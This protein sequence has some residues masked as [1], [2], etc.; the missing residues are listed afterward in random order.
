MGFRVTNPTDRDLRL[1]V[2]TSYAE[3][4]D[5]QY[6]RD[7][8]VP[9]HSTLTSWFAAG[10]PASALS[11][12]I[13][14][15]GSY[16]YDRSSG[17][18]RLI[19][20]KDGP[21]LWR[22]MARYTRRGPGT[23]VMLD[24]EL[25]DGTWQPTPAGDARADGV[26]NL[27][28]A[29]RAAGVLSEE[30]SW[31]HDRFLPPA[32]EAFDG[33]DHFVLA[34]DRLAD[35]PAG[36]A[37]VRA[38]LQRG[39]RLWVMLDQVKP[40]TVAALLG[41]ALEL[42][43]VNRVGLNSIPIR[44]GR[45]N[46][47][48]PED[49]GLEV[50][51]PVDFVRVLAPG[52]E[53][54]HTIHGWPASFVADFGRGKVVFTTLGARGWIRART[55][56]DPA[57]AFQQFPQLPIARVAFQTICEELVGGVERPVFSPADIEP[58]LKG[59]I[60]YAV[61]GR[62]PTLLVFGAF[63][64]AMAAGVVLLGRAGLAEY[65]GWIGPALALSAA[66][67]FIVLGER[68]RSAVP[69]TVAY[70]QL[71]DAADVNEVQLSGQM[72]VYRPAASEALA[73][74]DQGGDFAL[75]TEGLEGRVLRRVQTD[76]GRWHWENL[77]LP[78]GVRTGPFRATLR[79]EEPVVARA[80]FGPEGLEGRLPASISGRLEDVLIST[81]GPRKL[82]VSIAAD[83]A[84]RAGRAELLPLGQY[85]AGSLLDDQ[86]RDRQVLYSKT[87]AEP[88]PRAL[89]SRRLLLAWSAPLDPHF[90]FGPP[91]RL[92]GAAL[93]AI[94]LQ[95]EPS[96]PDT[97]VTIPAPFLECRQVDPLGNSRPPPKEFTEPANLRLRFQLPRC[98]MP[99]RVE[100]AWLTVRLN[101]PARPVVLGGY[102][103]TNAVA[104]QHLTS[105][106]GEQTV[107]IDDPRLL[108]PDEFGGLYAHVEIGQV[109]NLVGGSDGR[110]AWQI[111]SLELE[112][113]GR[114]LGGEAP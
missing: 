17:G 76:L 52:R 55:E 107:K 41:D 66:T 80:W 43:V 79:T 88:L 85:I 31:I 70:A 33:I 23:A 7:V 27:V 57:P 103:G 15:L 98:V 63:F 65:L 47:S 50:E 71:V 13:I 45:L 30:V 39:G 5:R 91:S 95:L 48:R 100:E 16:L 60:G 24:A 38:W 96:P 18:D 40:R 108:R 113:R 97:L 6:G 14:E 106:F 4:S 114:T 81:P 67:A 54:L 105:P 59:Q 111:E 112:V 26:R 8:W 104:L 69:P 84:F 2:L 73:G 86:Q 99:L 32:P 53:P 87:F 74:A 49:S 110:L 61:V 83:G 29:F 56:R 68:A 72:A 51:E 101:V 102:D 3:S 78:A 92:A 90:R 75:D 46:A 89:A 28:R 109:A 10:A 62:G 22:H 93:W 42:H 77:D 11:R 82:A 37:T 35:D 1:R 34:T 21:P 9:A 58:Y 20:S 94:P 12:S 36:L 19:R 64:F 25:H 44:H